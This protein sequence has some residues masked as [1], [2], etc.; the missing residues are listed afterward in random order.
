MYVYWN[1]SLKQNLEEIKKHLEKYLYQLLLRRCVWF[2]TMPQKQIR[3]MP[4]TTR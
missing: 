2:L 1:R 4:R 3:L